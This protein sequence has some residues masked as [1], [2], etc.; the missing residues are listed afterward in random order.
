MQKHGFSASSSGGGCEWYTKPTLHQ[1]TDAFIAITD[2]AG[3]G[4]PDSLDDAVLVGI[5]DAE[6]EDL[7]EKAKIFESLR[8]YLE[9]LD[10]VNC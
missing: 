10:K 2:G 6:T 1:G 5:Y 8:S 7:I 9:L 4:L 3:P